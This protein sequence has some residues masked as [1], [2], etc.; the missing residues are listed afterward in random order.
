MHQDVKSVFQGFKIGAEGDI[1]EDCVHGTRPDS[2]LTPPADASGAVHMQMRLQP[3]GH[4]YP[5]LPLGCDALGPDQQGFAVPCCGLPS[6]GMRGS[7]PGVTHEGF[8]G[9]PVR[10]PL[11]RDGHASGSP[12]PARKV[13]LVPFSTMRSPLCVTALWMGAPSS[14]QASHQC[15]S[16]L[17]PGTTSGAVNENGLWW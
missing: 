7:P 15:H 1:R 4:P 16:G 13:P 6:P 11:R 5:S 12:T 17:Q 9:S 14:P 2:K 8:R 10:Q 3:P